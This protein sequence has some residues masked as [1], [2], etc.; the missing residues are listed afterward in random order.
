MPVV[1]SDGAQPALYR[2]DAATATATRGLEVIASSISAIGK[3]E[4]AR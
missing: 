2:I 3:L 1:T 4:A